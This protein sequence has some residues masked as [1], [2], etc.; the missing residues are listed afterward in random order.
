[1]LIGS[2]LV[3]AKHAGRTGVSER[4]FRYDLAMRYKGE[5]PNCSQNEEWFQLQLANT[6]SQNVLR[7]A[8]LV[9]ERQTAHRVIVIMPVVHL[10]SGR[11]QS[12][13]YLRAS[14][15]ILSYALS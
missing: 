10:A 12:H 13:S 8:R 15:G 14:L 2:I 9:E 6:V 4:D 11:R 3:V 5:R 1:M 7:R